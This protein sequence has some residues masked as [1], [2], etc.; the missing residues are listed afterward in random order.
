[1]FRFQKF[2]QI[3]EIMQS[4]LDPMSCNGKINLAYLK[5]GKKMEANMNNILQLLYRLI[6]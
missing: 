4:I 3:G 5:S 1:M 6:S 2:N